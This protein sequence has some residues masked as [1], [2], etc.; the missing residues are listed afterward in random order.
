[1]CPNLNYAQNLAQIMIYFFRLIFQI[2]TILINQHLIIQWQANKNIFAVCKKYIY[3]GCLL[4]WEQCINELFKNSEWLEAFK[5]GLDIYH[6]E[7]KVLDGI[8][9][10]VKKRKENVKRILKGLIL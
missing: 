1:M 10:N 6:G 2:K 8:P 7:N 3:F 4:N 5:L 9:V